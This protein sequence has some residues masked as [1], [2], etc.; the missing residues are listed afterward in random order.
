MSSPILFYDGDCGFCNRSVQFILDHERNEAIQF[1]SL[2]SSVAQTYLHNIASNVSVG[3][4]MLFLKDGQ[5][6]R[7]SEAAIEV[8]AYLKSPWN[9]LTVFR[10]IPRK[11][12]DAMYDWI[13][14]NRK[15]LI[16]QYECRRQDEKVRRRF[17][18]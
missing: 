15:K 6:Y 10:F 5:L 8:T 17:L 18:S 7:K 1:C 13:A 2:Q 11:I 12:R 16:R 4:T 3:N 9:G 14:K